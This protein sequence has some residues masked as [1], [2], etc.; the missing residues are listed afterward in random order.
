MEPHAGAA[1]QDDIADTQTREFGD[2]GAG[3][4]QCGEHDPIPLPAPSIGWRRIKERLDLIFGEKAEQG[5]V[6]TLHRDR[7]DALEAWEGGR[8]FQRRKM[9]EGSNCREAC[10]STANRVVALALQVI[11]EGQDERR[12]QVGQLETLGSFAQVALSKL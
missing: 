7:E 6:E 2:P 3:V 4:V 8:I 9:R 11:E 1:V 5:L 12:V 10:I